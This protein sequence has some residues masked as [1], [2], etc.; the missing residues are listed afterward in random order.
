M[1]SPAA[2]LSRLD[3]ESP[4]L[5]CSA[6]SKRLTPPI[7]P[8]TTGA[9]VTGI[10]YPSPVESSPSG[11][12]SAARPGPPR[13]VSRPGSSSSESKN[14]VEISIPPQLDD[15]EALDDLWDALRQEKE[16]KMNREKAKVKSLEEFK[17]REVI[18][19]NPIPQSPSPRPG[20]S[21]KISNPKRTPSRVSS[22]HITPSVRTAERRTLLEEVVSNQE[23]DSFQIP[24][25]AKTVKK[26]KS[27]LSF[28]SS[29]TKNCI[30]A[31][32]D[33]RGIGRDDIRVT[34]RRDHILVSW[35]K[36]EIEDWA[37][38][39]CLCRRTVERVYHKVIPLAEGTKFRDIYGAMKGED[40]LLRYPLVGIN[41]SRES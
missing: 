21:S 28:H 32:F 37:E 40:L 33:F 36:W 29:P 31:I 4:A 24:S 15:F 27:I 20:S 41:G 14:F 35:E 13:R 22:P 6:R 5:T 39:D 8:A 23:Q 19:T 34:Y 26:K 17:P 18:N 1:A 11:M 12:T 3:M 9:G 2:Q 10:I 30:V 38:E 16:L 25:A 7:T